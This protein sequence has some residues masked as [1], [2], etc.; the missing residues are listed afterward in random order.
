MKMELRVKLSGQPLFLSL[1]TLVGIALESIPSFDAFAQ[2]FFQHGE[3]LISIAF[4]NC[5][6]LLLYTLQHNS[7]SGRIIA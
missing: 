5:Y 3:W 6:K 7:E 1:A 2:R 4:H